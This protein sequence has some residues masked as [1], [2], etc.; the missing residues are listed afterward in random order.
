MFRF[1]VHT[2]VNDQPSPYIEIGSFVT[3]EVEKCGIDLGV[4]VAVS[5]MEIF[6]AQRLAEGLSDD[7]EE[8]SVY[9][10]ARLATQSERKHL[11]VKNKKEQVYY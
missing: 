9:N 8:N 1:C 10:I 6:R 7:A 5:S 11:P 3:V 2:S 4:V